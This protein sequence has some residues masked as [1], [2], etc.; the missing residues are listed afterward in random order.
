VNGSGIA[1]PNVR[2]TKI[3]NKCNKHIY[4]QCKSERESDLEIFGARITDFAVVV[5]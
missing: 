4:Y 5:R 1:F 3:I 2:Q